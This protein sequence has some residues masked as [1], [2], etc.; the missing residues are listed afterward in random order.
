MKP[1]T[2]ERLLALALD[3]GAGK[4]EARAAWARIIDAARDGDAAARAWIGAR[5]A[6]EPASCDACPHLRRE[7]QRATRRVAALERELERAERERQEARRE[8]AQGRQEQRR[9][10]AAGEPPPASA[11][12]N[13]PEGGRVI[14]L[15]WDARCADP[16]CRA[17]LDAGTRARWWGRGR[18]YCLQHEGAA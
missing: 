10:R 5:G 4:H 14:T 9:Q 3:G 18:V 13:R 7:L 17:E 6:A 12:R 1:E 2:I 8:A 15:R 16:E 11:G